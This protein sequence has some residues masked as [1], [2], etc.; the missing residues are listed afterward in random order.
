MKFVLEGSAPNTAQL[1]INDVVGVTAVLLTCSYKDNQE[2]LRVGYYVNIEYDDQEMNENP[3]ATPDIARLTRHILAEKPR[4]TKFHIDWD[5]EQAQQLQMMADQQQEGMMQK[6]T[7]MMDRHDL[8]SHA[9]L[10]QA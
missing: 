10:A 3:P 2:F 9:N 4:V 1:P 8:M 6:G 7:Q 5:D